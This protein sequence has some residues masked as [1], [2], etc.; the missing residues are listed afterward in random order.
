MATAMST[1]F[2]GGECPTAQVNGKPTANR[3]SEIYE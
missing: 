3:G 2:G 1:F